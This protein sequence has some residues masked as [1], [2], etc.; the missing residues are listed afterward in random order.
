[1][2][3]AKN[4]LLAKAVEDSNT[5]AE[6]LTKAAG[7]KLGKVIN[8][9]YSW[10]EINIYSEPLRYD[11]AILCEESACNYDNSLDI[12]PEDLDISDTVTVVWEILS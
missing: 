7:V 11:K 10:G 1:M 4:Q 3:D 2:E 12:N 8:I 6:I 5:K 9:N